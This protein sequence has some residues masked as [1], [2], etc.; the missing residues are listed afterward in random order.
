M[1]A[2]PA[3]PTS[4]YLTANHLKLIASTATDG[5]KS[6]GLGTGTQAPQPH[7]TGVSGLNVVKVC[8]AHICQ[9]CSAQFWHGRIG[10]RSALAI[11]PRIRLEPKFVPKAEGLATSHTTRREEKS[12]L[13]N[14]GLEDWS[15]PKIKY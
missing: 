3:R 7:H 2:G 8:C 15:K 9:I 12:G 5:E 6:F 10:P 13:A 11:L 1:V 14:S 4:K